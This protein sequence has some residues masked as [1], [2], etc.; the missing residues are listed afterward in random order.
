[1]RAATADRDALG[2]F[3]QREIAVDSAKPV[4]QTTAPWWLAL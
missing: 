3:I 1:M 4:K 2:R